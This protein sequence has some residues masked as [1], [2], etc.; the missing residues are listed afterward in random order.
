MKNLK[1]LI[2]G[3]EETLIQ[4]VESI[5]LQGHTIVACVSDSKKIQEYALIQKL[6]YFSISDL[7][8]SIKFDYAIVLDDIEIN[9]QLIYKTGF[10]KWIRTLQKFASDYNGEKPVLSSIYNFESFI[11]YTYCS[12]SGEILRIIPN[13]EQEF[14]NAS[15]SIIETLYCILV[16]LSRDSLNCENLYHTKIIS[17]PCEIIDHLNLYLNPSKL[18]TKILLITA[19]NV[20]LSKYFPFNYSEYLSIGILTDIDSESELDITRTCKLLTIPENTNSNFTSYISLYFKKL[21][22]TI[23]RNNNSLRHVLDSNQAKIELSLSNNLSDSIRYFRAFF[24]RFD[25][26]QDNHHLLIVKYIPKYYSTYF[27]DDFSKNFINLLY[28][29][30]KNPSIHIDKISFL[31]TQESI[32][33]IPIEYS[34]Y[35]NVISLIEQKVNEFPDQIAVKYLEE[36]LTYKE[37]QRKSNF[38]AYQLLRNKIKKGDFIGVL[39]E[40]SIEFIYIIIGIMKAG[41]CYLPINP[42]LPI[43]RIRHIVESTNMQIVL[44]EQDGNYY[45][46]LFSDGR[47]TFYDLLNSE[48]EIDTFLPFIQEKDL[49]Y[50]LFTSGTTGMPKG[51]VIEHGALADRLLW[52]KEMLSINQND[53]ILHHSNISFDTSI[54]EIFLPLI[55]GSTLVL[56]PRD[57]HDKIADFNTIIN[58][59]KVTCVEFVPSLLKLFINLSDLRSCTSLKYVISGGEPLSYQLTQKFYQL[60]PYCLLLNLYG[61]TEATMNAAYYICQPQEIERTRYIPIGFPVANLNFY[62][63]DQ[64]RY[65]VPFG[66]IGELYLKG[67]G[68]AAGYIR[69]N[70]KL[71]QCSILDKN[72]GV[73]YKTGDLVRY[74]TD[75]ALEFIG[76]VDRQIKLRGYRIELE[77][78]ENVISKY[79]LLNQNAVVLYGQNESTTKI[80]AFISLIHKNDEEL[81]VLENEIREFC[82]KSLPYYMIPSLFVFLPKLPFLPSGKIDYTSLLRSLDKVDA[83]DTNV[84]IHFINE[85]EK[86][87]YEVW[88]TILE[89]DVPSFNTN[90][91]SLG[92]NSLSAVQMISMLRAKGIYLEISDI[93]ANATIEALANKASKKNYAT[94]ESSIIVPLKERTRIPLSYAQQRL[95][96]LYQLEGGG[97]SAYNMP[98]IFQLDGVLHVSYLKEAINII[99]QRHEI[100]R[101]IFKSKNGEPW[102]EILP[103]NNIELNPIKVSQKELENLIV[104]ETHIPFNIETGPLAR[105]RLFKV[106]DNCNILVI[107]MHNIIT[108]GWSEGIFIKELNSIYNALIN[109]QEPSLPNL[110]IQYADYSVWQKHKINQDKQA[111]SLPY[112]INKLSGFTELKLVSEVCIDN[113]GEAIGQDIK[114]DI[115]CP[116]LITAIHKLAKEKNT[117]PYVILVTAYTVLLSFYSN[118]DDVTFGTGFAGRNITELENLIG[119]FVNTI[120]LR[121]DLNGNPTFYELIEKVKI[122][123]DE[124]QQHQDVPFEKIVDALMLEREENKNPIFQTLFILQKYGDTIDLALS[125]LICSNIITNRKTS[126]FDITFNL[127][128]EAKGLSGDIQ[129]NAKLFSKKFIQSILN[130]FYR[131]LNL[132]VNNPKSSVKSVNIM[133]QVEL[134]SILNDWNQTEVVYNEEQHV[135]KNFEVQANLFPNNVAFIY[136]DESI[137]YKDL[138][139]RVEKLASLLRSKLENSTSVSSNHDIIGIY[140]EKSIEYVISMLA[141]M[142]IGSAFLPLDPEF[143]IERLNYYIQDSGV[144]Y[145]VC[146][147]NLVNL[148]QLNV[149]NFIEIDSYVQDYYVINKEIRLDSSNLCYV[150]YTSGSTGVPKGVEICHGAVNNLL[151]FM[152]D[153]LN[154]SSNERMLSLTSINFDIVYLELLLPLMYGASC[155]ITPI[156]EVRDNILVKNLI[157]K[158]NPTYIQATPSFWSTFIKDN[159]KYKNINILTGGEI[160]H[161]KLAQNLCDIFQD[162]W[163]VYGP[164]EVTI[165]STI[166]KID[167]PNQITIGT[168][169]ANTKCYVLDEYL[170]PVPTGVIGEL[171]IS[172]KGLATGYRNKQELT[173]LFFI[174]NPFLST[175]VTDYKKIYKTG[176]L[177]RYTYTGEIQYIGRKDQ[178]IKMRG[179]RIE[180]LEIEANILKYETIKEVVVIFTED[181]IRAYCVPKNQS[182][183]LNFNDIYEFICKLLPVYMIPSKWHEI[184]QI[185]KTHSGKIDRNNLLLNIVGDQQQKTTL[186]IEPFNDIQSRLLKIWNSVLK[187]DTITLTDSFYMIGGHSLLIPPIV[188]SI[189]S[190]F[191]TQMTIR[192]FIPNNTLLKLSK[193]IESKFELL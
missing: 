134:L 148:N 102:Q 162:V 32:S 171:Y 63:L 23:P 159:E 181:I 109:K 150:I 182:I 167:N 26:S 25:K 105:Y 4:A 35:E 79:H 90:F 160:L 124:A 9:S 27:I 95:W 177:V 30:T 39:A 146:D 103:K 122:T 31:Q 117:S 24:C 114:I 41:G 178:Q 43:E 112:W 97:S 115:Y 151:K 52:L 55:S 170:K 40:R 154:F 2:I 157:T 161:T 106:K 59:Y 49:S 36:S 44:T 140:M 93:F 37:L 75:H 99:I 69:N 186:D 84:D 60:A 33:Q 46:D 42:K 77:E 96:Y 54:E 7:D 47:I 92:G 163:N 135:Y 28:N 13:S 180:L 127:M 136:K 14:S 51:V 16:D 192:D 11:W 104:N 22:Q 72:L 155:I 188:A 174:P 19:F 173:D 145:A 8:E 57:I 183:R 12:E 125:N 85:I 5:E 141:I 172:G 101:T 91:F 3:K 1:I 138:N 189:N 76:R 56:A 15:A 111:E 88:L 81:H 158:F 94:K 6:K 190:E 130:T 121:N 45:E 166:K 70:A 67:H 152:G 98:M 73:L 34:G 83:K 116:D 132:L 66:G 10:N 17:L 176:D 187:I 120:V 129:Y 78:I 191:A 156:N 113:A 119:F 80:V 50:I 153:K 126:T 48:V 179:H 29:I 20:L 144:T 53:I 175:Y 107:T 38:I 100:L 108:D 71:E 65:I 110:T 139:R 169:I 131:I 147:S 118:Q 123:C 143:P 89:E 142:K 58:F 82:G 62:I 128:L 165:W 21:L 185:P 164:T 64:N 87:I 137:T 193:Y 184:K 68:I 61:P 86:I 133:D 18:D 74:L 149:S 168:P